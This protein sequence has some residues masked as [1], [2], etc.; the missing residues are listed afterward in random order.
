MNLIRVNITREISFLQYRER[1][2][3]DQIAHFD[4]RILAPWATP[5][6][7]IGPYVILSWRGERDYI[8]YPVSIRQLA[9]GIGGYV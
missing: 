2:K 8:T 9:L 5:Q 6:S 4:Q 7:P 1:S 3:N